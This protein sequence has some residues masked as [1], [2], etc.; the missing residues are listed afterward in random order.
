MPKDRCVVPES[1]LNILETWGS[2]DLEV[3][4]LGKHAGLLSCGADG[5]LVDVHAT[6]MW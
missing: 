2:V 6:T 1:P 5:D 3:G 4:C